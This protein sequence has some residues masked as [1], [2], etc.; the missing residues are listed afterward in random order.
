MRLVF[1]TY[2]DFLT[3]TET[4]ERQNEKNKKHVQ[5]DWINIVLEE[6]YT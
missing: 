4:V 2:G 1:E 5:V 3:K 6:K